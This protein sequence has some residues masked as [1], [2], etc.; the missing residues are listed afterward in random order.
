MSQE[1]LQQ[2]KH[3]LKLIQEGKL[4]LL[5]E[6]LQREAHLFSELPIKH[7]G[8][9]GDTLL[10]YAA[11]HGHLPIL[12][13]LVEMVGMDVEV[14][15]SDYKRPLHEAASLGHRD[16]LLYLIS[17]G[18][19]V[20][21]L[22]KADWTPLMMACAK[23]NLDVIKD[24]I[25]HRA[26]PML[27]NKDGWNCFHIATREGESAV[28]RYLLD[29]FPGIWNTESKIKRTPL[30]TA[31]MHGCFEVVAV[32]LERCNYEPDCKDSCGVTPFMDAV[33]NGHLRIAQLLIDKKKASPTKH[34]MPP[35]RK[36]K[37]KFSPEEL[38]ILAEE[39]SQNHKLL[40][41]SQNSMAAATWKQ[42][43]WA[44]VLA[45]INA[46]GVTH[47]TVTDLKKRWHDLRRKARTKLA[48]I[49]RETRQT[50]GGGRGEATELTNVEEMAARTLGPEFIHGVG[51]FD[52]LDSDGDWA[53][54][55]ESPLE[56]EDDEGLPEVLYALEEPVIPKMELELDIPQML[57]ETDQV[58][59]GLPQEVVWPIES[60]RE[61]NPSLVH[62]SL[63]LDGAGEDILQRT[64]EEELASLGLQ[65]ISVDSPPHTRAQTHT[66][67]SPIGNVPNPTVSQ[68]SPQLTSY[69][70]MM[71]ETARAN[72]AILRSTARE[73]N[74]RLASL[75]NRLQRQERT[76]RSLVK[77]LTGLT[78]RTLQHYTEM[79]SLTQ[80]VCQLAE[81]TS[82]LYSPAGPS[83]TQQPP[84]SNAPPTEVPPTSSPTTPRFGRGARLRG[85]GR[86][87]RRRGGR[88]PANN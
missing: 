16:C 18:A 73:R 69:Q 74:R 75:D 36:R 3:I 2:Q 35:A 71:L 27:R 9:S 41:G 19:E 78:R 59:P 50:G 72:N 86:G 84:V 15:N 28:I 11:R 30:H 48:Q 55:A 66:L 88:R 45:R 52:A 47:R 62:E 81:S 56:E 1:E 29:V 21:C 32:L 8:R 43:K 76:I 58:S 46:Q 26:N 67:S 85:R 61:A 54:S 22:K 53:S 14:L 42:E 77:V 80:A 25:E 6:E 40:F 64:R 17:K 57:E 33:Q 79:A 10:H 7:F 23:R 12:S 5:Q 44:E 63:A 24:L 38:E 4:S 39:L 87:A 51:G 37:R 49:H 34:P 13:Y 31:A 82:A 70:H 68:G 65:V 60:K 83:N 20:D